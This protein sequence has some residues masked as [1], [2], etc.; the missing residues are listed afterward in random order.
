MGPRP[1]AA[2]LM[3]QCCKIGSRRLAL[4]LGRKLPKGLFPFAF[5][6]GLL[7]CRLCTPGTD[8]LLCT[9]STPVLARLAHLEE[10]LVF[11]TSTRL[12]HLSTQAVPAL[13]LRT[14]K[15]QGLVCRDYS[16]QPKVE[17]GSGE[18]WQ[19]HVQS[20]SLKGNPVCLSAL[21]KRV[22][23]KSVVWRSHFRSFAVC[24][25]QVAFWGGV[26][27]Q[28]PSIGPTKVLLGRKEISAMS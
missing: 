2:L 23:F 27:G 3:P 18:P 4:W 14:V 6:L 13:L 15:D 17:T 5:C 16:N 24:L 1:S 11:A 28:A 22:G 25:R 9:A 19:A 20:L 10:S 8:M 21:D 7:P 12:S 26:G